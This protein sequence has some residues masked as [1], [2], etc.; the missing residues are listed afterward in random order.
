M[1]I[2]LNYKM[3]YQKYWLIGCFENL[4]MDIIN[5]IIKLTLCKKFRL[6]F[7][8]ELIP[9]NDFEYVYDNIVY[10]AKYKKIDIKNVTCRIHI[11]VENCIITKLTIRYIRHESGIEDVYALHFEKSCIN[12]K[13]LI[14][15]PINMIYKM[16]LVDK[17]QNDGVYTILTGQYQP[18]HFEYIID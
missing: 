2:G 11:I 1:I 7:Y 12:P 14:L 17:I 6:P 3:N 15:K 10:K 8:E 9:L 16:C 13:Y 4:D 18:V 5:I